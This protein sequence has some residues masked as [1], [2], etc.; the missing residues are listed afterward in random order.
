MS[1]LGATG[2]TGNPGGQSNG[3]I[4]P[5]SWR[6][7]EAL[8][9]KQLKQHLRQQQQ[10][11]QQQNTVNMDRMNM[12]NSMKMTSEGEDHGIQMTKK[13]TLKKIMNDEDRRTASSES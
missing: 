12:M 7:G 5:G 6:I 9:Q 11:K 10:Q 3:L 13:S 8:V 1:K 2:S 4:T